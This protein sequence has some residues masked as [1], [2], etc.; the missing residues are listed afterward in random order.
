MQCKGLRNF[1][2]LDGKLEHSSF[3]GTLLAILVILVGNM[4]LNLK[5]LEYAAANPVTSVEIERI[6]NYPELSVYMCFR[7]V[8]Q[9]F[10]L[11]PPPDLPFF[12]RNGTSIGAARGLLHAK[13]AGRFMNFY[14]PVDE[15]S[16][17]Q[18]QLFSPHIR[19]LISKCYMLNP[20]SEYPQMSQHQVD[21]G[22]EFLTFHFGWKASSRIPRG[23][24]CAVTYLLSYAGTD[25]LKA[26]AEFFEEGHL[27]GDP[28]SLWNAAYEARVE[29]EKLT[30]LDGSVAY[31]PLINLAPVNDLQTQ[32]TNNSDGTI[33]Q[34]WKADILGEISFVNPV[35]FEWNIKAFKEQQAFTYLDLLTSFFSFISVVMLLFEMGFTFD[36]YTGK[37][38]F[39]FGERC[40][41]LENSMKRVHPMLKKEWIGRRKRKKNADPIS[42]EKEVIIS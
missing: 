37:I 40:K 8:D 7:R 11:C 10:N 12:G 1:F 13:S 42:L 28:I 6:R 4:Y 30:K 32:D 14:H 41:E 3:V 20:F 2:L 27:M 9:F 31:K 29:L 38:Y 18:M 34:G 15:I 17:A 35:G 25:A 39:R 5:K 26:E 19:A 36:P 33:T 16:E 24:K 21:K 22:L 23:S